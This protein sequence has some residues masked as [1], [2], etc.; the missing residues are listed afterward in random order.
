[1][2]T[3]KEDLQREFGYFEYARELDTDVLVLHFT[4][5][6]IVLSYGTVIIL[7]VDGCKPVLTLSHNYSRTTAKHRNT[8]LGVTSKEFK[9]TNYRIVGWG[10]K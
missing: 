5:G 7:H 9:E 8:Y 2:I 3:E 1:M 4:N 6:K 10:V